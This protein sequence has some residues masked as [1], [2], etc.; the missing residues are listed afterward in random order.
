VVQPVSALRQA[1]CV[2]SGPCTGGQAVGDLA[3][4][5]VVL[6]TDD[7]CREGTVREHRSAQPRPNEKGG[8]E[9]IV[10]GLDLPRLHR[11]GSG[12]WSRVSWFSE[13]FVKAAASSNG[14]FY[15]VHKDVPYPLLNGRMTPRVVE[16]RG[17]GTREYA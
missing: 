7:D 17:G 16:R 8:G 6:A 10:D 5:L 13:R 15:L 11:V 1:G 4:V 3:S 9:V 2:D 12:H 14:T